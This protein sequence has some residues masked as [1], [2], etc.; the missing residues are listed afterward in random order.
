MGP[1]LQSKIHFNNTPIKRIFTEPDKVLRDVK[2]FWQNERPYRKTL[3]WAP[4]TYP[5]IL[6]NFIEQS[7]N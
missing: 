2:S 3:E 7:R 5:Y 1:C 6:K 4:P